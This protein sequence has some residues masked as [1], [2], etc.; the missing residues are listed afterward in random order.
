M[1]GGIALHRGIELLILYAK[2]YSTIN[3]RRQDIMNSYNHSFFFVLNF[4]VFAE[5]IPMVG[6][7]YHIGG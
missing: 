7:I 5:Y 3:D 6:S 1:N 2:G 4:Q